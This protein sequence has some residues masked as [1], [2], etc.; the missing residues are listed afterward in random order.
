MRAEYIEEPSGVLFS[1][2]RGED[3]VSKSILESYAKEV[4]TPEGCVGV[5]HAYKTIIQQEV[6]SNTVE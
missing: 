2:L 5:Y 6:L 3:K 1:F 4:L